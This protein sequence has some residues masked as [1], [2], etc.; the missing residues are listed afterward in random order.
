[1]NG[2]LEDRFVEGRDEYTTLEMWIRQFVS[3]TLGIRL[4]V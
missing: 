4:E 3:G 1:M 2:E